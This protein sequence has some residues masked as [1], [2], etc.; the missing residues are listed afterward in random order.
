MIL[1]AYTFENVR[2]LF[3]SG[4]DR[5]PDGLGNT[6]N[7]LGKHFMSKMFPTSMATFLTWFS[8]GTPARGAGGGA[9]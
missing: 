7:Q 2:L 6:T 3:L 5:H 4:D 8:T 9:G 1:A